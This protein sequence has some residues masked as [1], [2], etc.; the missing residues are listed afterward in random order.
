MKNVEFKIQISD[1][2]P[3]IKLLKIN[4]A[5]KISILN[6]VDTY[7]NCPTGRFKLRETNNKIFELIYYQRAD[8]AKFKVSEYQIIY[9]NKAQKNQLLNLLIDAYGQKVVVKKKREFWL[10][11]NTRVLLDT[12]S[13][14]GNFLELETL[15]MKQSLRKAK[16]EQANVIELLGLNKFKKIKRSYSVYC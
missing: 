13:K 6:Q 16:K 2:S 10:Y 8:Q 7:F 14:L 11:H 12:V 9:I 15:T 1:H 4:N 3:I 5:R